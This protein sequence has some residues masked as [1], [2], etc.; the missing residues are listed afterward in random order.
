MK[1]I[2]QFV[3]DGPTVEDTL[4]VID[5]QPIGLTDSIEI[6]M[7]RHNMLPIKRV[8]FVKHDGKVVADEKAIAALKEA[9]FDISIREI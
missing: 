2:I 7:D 8:T 6:N 4:L 5:G 3:C 1:H 9:G